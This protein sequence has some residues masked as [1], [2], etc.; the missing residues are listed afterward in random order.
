MNYIDMF[1]MVLLVWSIFKGYTRGLIMQLS[2]MIAVVAG[3]Y[4]ALKLSGFTARQLEGRLNIDAEYLYLVSLGLTFL[5][6]FMGIN[7]LGRLIEKMVETAQLSMINRLLG[8]LFSAGK[9]VVITG[10]LLVLIDRVDQKVTILPKNSREHSLFYTPFTT[11]VVSVF[12][13]MER[14]SAGKLTYLFNTYHAVK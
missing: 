14:E 4:L 5:L 9:T 13:F 6:V 3:I 8:V 10:V 2:L 12:P 11:L 7:L 1:I